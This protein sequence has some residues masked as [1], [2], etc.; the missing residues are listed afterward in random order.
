M[1]NPI[2]IVSPGSTITIRFCVE[3]QQNNWFNFSCVHCGQYNRPE[4]NDMN[5]IT[6]DIKED[7][8]Y[9]K[10]E[11]IETKED[12]I[13][14]KEEKYDQNDGEEEEEEDDDNFDCEMSEH[15]SDEDPDLYQD[16]YSPVTIIDS[17]NDADNESSC[18]EA[19]D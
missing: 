3:Y 7:V 15:H 6:N 18:S 8:I 2:S 9:I 16:I 11:N 4:V 5:D 1:T 10:E 13:H 17:E 19:G 12:V 14:S